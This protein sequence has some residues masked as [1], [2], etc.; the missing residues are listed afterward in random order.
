[1]ITQD[2]ARYVLGNWAEKRKREWEKPTKKN[3]KETGQRLGGGG[4][5]GQ[6]EM[7]RTAEDRASYITCV[8]PQGISERGEGVG[9][10]QSLV[11][12]SQ[13]FI[14]YCYSNIY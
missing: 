13:D 6:G 3:W 9:T 12:L 8:V 11:L 7:K 14:M 4:G 10:P 1:M 5:L 2:D